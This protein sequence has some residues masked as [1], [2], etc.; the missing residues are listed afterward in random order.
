MNLR[1]YISDITYIIPS[2]TNSIA[3]EFSI[4]DNEYCVSQFKLI[5]GRKSQ[6]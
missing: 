6:C 3:E 2:L 5:H 1:K 4:D